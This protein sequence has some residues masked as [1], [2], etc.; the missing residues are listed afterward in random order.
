MKRIEAII[1]PDMVAD[2]CEALDRI[3]HHGVTISAVEGRSAGQGWAHHV[4]CGSYTDSARARSRMEV[5]VNDEDA[6]RTIR[7]IRDAAAGDGAEDGNIFVHDLVDVVRIRTNESG[8][9]AL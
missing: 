1:G 3:G 4:R 6:G 8:A 7:T 9:A 5:V 2:L